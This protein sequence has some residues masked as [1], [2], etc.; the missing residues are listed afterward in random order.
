MSTIG[1][2]SATLLTPRPEPI[3]KSLCLKLLLPVIEPS[4]FSNTMFY[5]S[6]HHYRP[7][8]IL[9]ADDLDGVRLDYNYSQ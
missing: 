8:Q 9:I 4:A 1:I 6:H 2:S 3:T 7:I 5:Y